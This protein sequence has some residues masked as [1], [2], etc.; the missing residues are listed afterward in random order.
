MKEGNKINN[1]LI[2]V[3]PVGGDKQDE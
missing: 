2:H 3:A 1:D